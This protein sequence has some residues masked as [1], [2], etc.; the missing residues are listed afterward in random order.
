MRR[1]NDDICYRGC[2]PEQ[3]GGGRLV[4]V[5]AGGEFVGLLP[6]RVKHS[7]TGLM[8]GYAGSGPADLARSL[9][10]HTLGDAARCAV[11]GG[12]PQPQKCPW[13]D[14]GWIVPSSTYQRFTFEVIARLPDCGWTLRRSDVL[15]WLQGAEGCC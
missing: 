6:H 10:I 13:C 4:T 14:E 8:W 9:L 2:E 7:P 3:T 15:D 11:C 1:D 5:E 12:A